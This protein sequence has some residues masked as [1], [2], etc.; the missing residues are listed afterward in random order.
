MSYCIK[1]KSHKKNVP[2]QVVN[3]SEESWLFHRFVVI[4][5]IGGMSYM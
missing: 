4:F 2:L 3:E 5:V 1:V